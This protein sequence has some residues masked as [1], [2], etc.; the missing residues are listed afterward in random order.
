MTPSQPEPRTASG[1]MLKSAESTQGPLNVRRK[2]AVSC[3]MCK[4]ASE[5]PSECLK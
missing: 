2:A 1:G 5:R 3:M 4:L